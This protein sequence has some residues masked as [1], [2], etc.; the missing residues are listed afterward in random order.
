MVG[1]FYGAR[2]REEGHKVGE[3]RCLAVRIAFLECVCPRRGAA[4]ISQAI[5]ISEE[6]NWSCAV[7]G[8]LDL[9][10]M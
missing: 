7:R 2:E 6:T 10:A 9:M 1:C 3:L 8:A 4:S 5:C